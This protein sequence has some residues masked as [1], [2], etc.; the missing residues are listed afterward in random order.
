LDI[1]LFLLL[2]V[3]FERIRRRRNVVAEKEFSLLLLFLFSTLERGGKKGRKN[4]LMSLI[5]RE[6]LIVIGY[7]V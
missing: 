5:L 2:V 4:E 3:V 7:C 1:F 6:F